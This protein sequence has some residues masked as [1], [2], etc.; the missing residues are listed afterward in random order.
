MRSFVCAFERTFASLKRDL[1]FLRAQF[2]QNVVASPPSFLS[3]FLPTANK[4]E[5]KKK[6]R[7]RQNGTMI[8]Y[9]F[10]GYFTL[11]YSSNI[12]LKRERPRRALARV[13]SARLSGKGGGE[14]VARKT[15]FFCTKRALESFWIKRMKV[16]TQY[17]FFSLSGVRVRSRR[18]YK[19][20]QT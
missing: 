15:S 6:G 14:I 1:F 7:R 5:R 2:L 17:V 12:R 3:K 16:L 20:L 8:Y 13:V 19:S 18:E 9:I 4:L 10:F 11:E